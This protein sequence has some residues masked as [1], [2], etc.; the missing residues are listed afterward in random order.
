MVYPSADNAGDLHAF[1]PTIDSQPKY[2]TTSHAFR[3][4]QPDNWAYGHQLG[5][6][7]GLHDCGYH[8]NHQ[9]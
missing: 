8:L 1:I 5:A 3:I 2:N 4:Q 7:H 6:E 9:K